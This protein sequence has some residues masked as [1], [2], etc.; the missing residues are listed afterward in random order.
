MQLARIP[1]KSGQVVDKEIV[2]HALEFTDISYLSERRYTELSGGE[3]QRVQ[4]ARVFAQIWREADARSGD[5]AEARRLLLLD[6]PTNALDLGHQAELMRAIRE[7]RHMGV[8]I[9]M[10]LHD[11]NL[12][13]SFADRLLALQCSQLM[14]YG[15]V[16]E[17]MTLE[18]MQ[19]LYSTP[20]SINKD[21]DSGS[22]YVTH[23]KP[24]N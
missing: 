2:E 14:A 8:G 4:L 10:V 21:T 20:L 13:A 6:E 17:V 3:K 16:E 5:G 19:A 23:A 22:I 11:I 1:H 7:L 24:T 18:T 9:V 12:A 15:S